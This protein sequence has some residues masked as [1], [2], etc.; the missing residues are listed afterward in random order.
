MKKCNQKWFNPQKV[1]KQI[2]IAVAIS[3]VCAIPI[4]TFAQVLKFSIKK[5]NTSIQSVLQELEKGSEYTFF[6]NDNQVKLD[7]KVSINVED[8]PIEVVLNQIFENSGYSYRIVEMNNAIA[9]QIK[10]MLV[11]NLRI[12]ENILTYD[13]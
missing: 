13:S 1:K 3:L 8:A 12:P 2:A 6:Y 7:K 10:E 9:D 4:S 5:S 11:E